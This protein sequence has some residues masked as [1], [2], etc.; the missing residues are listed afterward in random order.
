[1]VERR[2]YALTGLPPEVV[3]VAFAKTSRSPE[4]FDKIAEELNADKSGKFHEKWVVGYGHSSVAEHAVLSIAIE[5]VSIL[6]TKVIEDNRLASFTEKSTRYQVFDKERYYKPAKIMNSDLGKMYQDTADTILETYQRL[7]PVMVEFL[8]KKYP[9]AS[10]IEIKNKALDNLRNLLPV[11]VLTNLGMTIN[12]RNL[13]HGIVKLLSHPLGEMKEIG[14]EIKEAALKVTPTLI[15]YTKPNEYL[16][17]TLNSIN[18]VSD[19]SVEDQASVVLADFDKEA[20]D[21]LVTAILYR[22]SNASYE[23]VSEKV[24]SMSKEEKESV[25]DDSL[26]RLG[27]FDRPLRELEHIYYTFDILV[28]YGAFRDIQRHRIMTQ[29]NQDFSPAHGF[30][31]PAE[32]KEA[33][34]EKDFVESMKQAKMTFEI[35]KEQFPKESQYI[36]PMAF[37]KRVLFK[38]NLRELFHFIKLRSGKMGHESYRKIAQQMY[39]EVAKVHPFIA[40][41]IEVCKD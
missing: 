17:E 22:F 35:L 20:Q 37:K 24:K 29:T 1:M 4:P 16:V 11:S 2:I 12:A 40:K 8:K 18:G 14:E 41:Y 33:D 23:K 15:K 26:K 7:I 32:V 31:V 10:E 9:D 28:D 38:A 34:M 21:K 5:N 27:K 3:A 6:A 30:D 36:L 19:I 25:I 39:D 13:E